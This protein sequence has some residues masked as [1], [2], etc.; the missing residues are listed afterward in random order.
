MTGGSLPQETSTRIFMRGSAVVPFTQYGM[1][2]G[3]HITDALSRRTWNLSSLAGPQ[4]YFPGSHNTLH[5]KGMSSRVAYASEWINLYEEALVTGSKIK[6]TIRNPVYPSHYS[7]VKTPST[8][9]PS[10]LNPNTMY[11]FWYMRYNYCRYND[12]EDQI[13]TTTYVGHDMGST[14]EHQWTS[15]REFMTDTSVTW[16][17]DKLPRATKMHYSRPANTSDNYKDAMFPL[18][19]QDSTVTYE[20]EFNNKP[21]KL[22]AAF[23]RKKHFGQP[24]R[25]A[26]WQPTTRLNQSSEYT[27]PIGT[28][29]ILYVRAGYA[30]FNAAGDM[31]SHVPADAIP[32]KQ[33]EMTYVARI[34]LRTPK[35][36]PW[37]DTA[38]VFGGT[39]TG[40]QRVPDSLEVEPDLDIEDGFSDMDLEEDDD[41][42]LDEQ[43]E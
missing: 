22:I 13:S 29:P 6:L 41:E 4:M 17:R 21:I 14:A 8:Y 20:L 9:D 38:K 7:T 19:A 5:P 11:G 16:I 30:G 23:S 24:Q 15:M 39:G 3:I 10:I 36:S 33:V 2:P 37:T 18:D 27:T 42:M 35:V 1:T 31:V 34:K 40:F 25:L 32:N 43:I 12:K 26:S 28:E